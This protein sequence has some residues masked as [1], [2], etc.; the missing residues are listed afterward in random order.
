M[1]DVYIK[2]RRTGKASGRPL[3]EEAVKFLYLYIETTQASRG[4]AITGSRHG[5]GSDIKWGIFK[6]KQGEKLQR[7]DLKTRRLQRVE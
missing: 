5:R 7:K 2:I 4:E 3:G 1:S 6:G